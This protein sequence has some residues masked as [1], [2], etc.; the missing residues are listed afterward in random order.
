MTVNDLK[1]SCIDGVFTVDMQSYLNQNAIAGLQDME[2]K[3]EGVDMEFPSNLSVG[4]ELND[5]SITFT[6]SNMG[7]TMMKMNVKITD[8]KVEA[9]E[10]VTTPAGTFSCYKMTYKTEMQA[11]G[12]YTTSSIEWFALDIGSVRSETYDKKGNLESYSVLTHFEN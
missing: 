1:M 5:A 3:I 6:A 8:R 7:I 2:V 10:D 12:K 9:I 4:Q 11:F